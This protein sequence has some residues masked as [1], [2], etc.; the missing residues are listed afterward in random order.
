ML[1]ESLRIGHFSRDPQTCGRAGSYLCH[2][3]HNVM[4]MPPNPLSTLLEPHQQGANPFRAANVPQV[5]PE[6]LIIRASLAERRT[7]KRTS[8]KMTCV[9]IFGCDS[10]QA[11]RCPACPN[12]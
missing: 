9:L 6:E 5:I 12:Q 1:R 3:L 7:E 4:S 11:T 10:I 2:P 8:F